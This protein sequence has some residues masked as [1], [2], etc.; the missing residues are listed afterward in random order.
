MKRRESRT[1]RETCGHVEIF[2][3]KVYFLFINLKWRQ[4]GVP[5]CMTEQVPLYGFTP[6]SEPVSSNAPA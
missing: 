5:P 1:S 3:K 4:G 6:Y 2:Q